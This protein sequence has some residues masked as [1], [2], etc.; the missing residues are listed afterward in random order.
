MRFIEVVLLEPEKNVVALADAYFFPP[1]QPSLLP[2]TKGGPVILGKLPPRRARLVVYNKRSN[3]TSIWIVELSEVHAATRG[4]HHRGKVI[5]SEVVLV[6]QPSMDAMEYAE[7]EAAV[8]SHPP[9]IEAM[10]K[11]GV[12]DMDLV[13]VDAWYA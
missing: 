7:C 2:R 11:R 1:F 6:V 8:K 12:E 5:S 13:M 10:R 3:E 4:G 9:F